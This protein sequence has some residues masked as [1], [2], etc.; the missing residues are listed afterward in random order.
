MIHKPGDIFKLLNNHSFF[1][2]Y[3]YNL[4]ETYPQGKILVLL[5]IKNSNFKHHWFY[6]LGGL[7]CGNNADHLPYFF[8]K[9]G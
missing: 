1:I 3:P 8:Q 7:V 6:F 2:D 4:T 5:K 9:I